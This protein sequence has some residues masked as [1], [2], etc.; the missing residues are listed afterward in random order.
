MS[1]I[2][3]HDFENAIQKEKEIEALDDPAVR[4]LGVRSRKLSNVH[5]GLS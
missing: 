4:A 3:L 5:K 1:W 2:V